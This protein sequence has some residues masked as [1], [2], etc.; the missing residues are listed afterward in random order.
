[1]LRRGW[2]SFQHAELMRPAVDATNGAAVA[3]ITGD[4]RAFPIGVHFGGSGENT[5][6]HFTQQTFHAV[7]QGVEFVRLKQISQPPVRFA[8]VRQRIIELAAVARGRLAVELA[9]G[10]EADSPGVA[11]GQPT[12]LAGAVQNLAPAGARLVTA[13]Q[14]YVKNS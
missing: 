9:Q 10:I 11:V 5:P 8:F 4:F 14:A 12:G 7:E 2:I 6:A 13:A 3:E 1:M